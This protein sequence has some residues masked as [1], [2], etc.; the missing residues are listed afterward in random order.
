MLP[1]LTP[2]PAPLVLAG[3]GRV[4]RQGVPLLLLQLPQVQVEL[5]VVPLLLVVLVVPLLLVLQLEGLAQLLLPVPCLLPLVLLA[6]L[7]GHQAQMGALP[8]RLSP[9]GHFFPSTFQLPLLPWLL[10]APAHLRPQLHLL[11]WQV[12]GLLLGPA[13][14]PPCQTQALWLQCWSLRAAWEQAV[15]PQLLGPAEQPRDLPR[16]AAASASAEPA[17]QGVQLRKAAW[18]MRRAAAPAAG[19]S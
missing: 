16:A 13:Q 11:V 17:M 6:L 18:E 3:Q 5:L 7:Q 8:P 15:P 9:R 1:P 19:H 14:L 4:G 10:L 12:L 2:H